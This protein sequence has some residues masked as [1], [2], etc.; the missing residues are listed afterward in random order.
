MA[1][2]TEKVKVKTP[3]FR[4]SFAHVFSP[5]PALEEGDKPKYNLVALFPKGTDLKDLK[6]AAMEVGKK[7]FGAK[8]KTDGKTWPVGFKNP[9]RDAAEKEDLEGY[10]PGTTFCTFGANVDY[11]P[12]VFDKDV[13]RLDPL[14]AADRAK[15]YSGC[16]AVAT[17]NVFAFEHPKGG[18]GIAFGLLGVQ[19]VK[20]DAKFG[21][22]AGADAS[23]F[24]AVEDE[25]DNVD[26]FGA[27]ED[28]DQDGGF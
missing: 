28:G 6:R 18:K 3:K 24:E 27:E 13:S 9:F 20:D 5:Q 4:V 10:T 19:K 12:T 23:D 17:I 11:P 7:K 2:K 1:E 8:W 15:F 25:S 14:D 22:G 26:N 21:G 16:W